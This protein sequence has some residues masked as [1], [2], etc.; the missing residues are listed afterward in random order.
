MRK[1]IHDLLTQHDIRP[2]L[3]DIGA[4]G[5]PMDIW[6]E[7]APH[8]IYVGFDADE[9]EIQDV[10]QSRFFDWNIIRKAAT[11][12]EKHEVTFH[13]TKS[14]YCSSML[15][16]DG[17]SL[18]QYLFSDLFL[19]ED[20]VAAPSITLD[21]ALEDLSLSS[22]DWFKTDS[23]GTDLRLFMSLRDEIRDRVL[24]IDIEPGLIDAYVGE[25]LF[26]DAHRDFVQ[27]GF[28][29][30]SLD[31]NGTVRMRRSSLQAASAIDPHVT[32]SFIYQAVRDTPGW[33]NARYFRT[34]DW[35]A[36]GDFTSRDYILS[37]AFAIIDNQPGFAFDLALEYER[38]FGEGDVTQILQRE[39]ILLMRNAYQ[40]PRRSMRRFLSRVK[41]QGWRIW[42]KLGG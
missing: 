1:V 26:V 23:Q 3:L 16:P 11:G 42:N 27:K 18:S 41:G 39:A 21:S 9:R 36:K 37:W 28:W 5:S 2:V 10:H 14:P 15:P 8:S 24:A 20:E 22:V 32:E 25:D 34:L 13:L 40:S 7:I 31:V 4:S 33:C 30:S 19:V 29:L 38:L 35:L 6:E 17:D 12:E